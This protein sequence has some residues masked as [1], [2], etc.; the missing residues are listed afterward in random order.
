MLVCMY[1]R[2]W[3]ICVSVCVCVSRAQRLMLGNFLNYSSS[4]T[5]RRGVFVRVLLL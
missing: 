3:S 4:Y 5:L 1:V 2:V